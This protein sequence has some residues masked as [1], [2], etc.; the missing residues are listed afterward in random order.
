MT[1]LT[2]DKNATLRSLGRKTVFLIKCAENW[3][4]KLNCLLGFGLGDG[5]GLPVMVEFGTSSGF[6]RLV[7]VSYL[8]LKSVTR[9]LNILKD[10]IYIEVI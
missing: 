8:G 3:C 2:L 7:R 5:L 4:T 10:C 9:N 1:F 6:R